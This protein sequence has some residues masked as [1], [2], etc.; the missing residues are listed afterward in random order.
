MC[1]I[2]NL[3]VSKGMVYMKLKQSLK[4]VTRDQLGVCDCTRK[5]HG[6]YSRCRNP[7]MRHS[8]VS[9][10]NVNVCISVL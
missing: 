4:G 1:L 10:M 7:V 8:V 6:Q 5:I 3:R 2:G 9:H